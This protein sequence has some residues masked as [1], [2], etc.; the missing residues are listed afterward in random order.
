MEAETAGGWRGDI[1]FRTGF[2]SIFSAGV[3]RIEV[4]ICDQAEEIDRTARSP[5]SATPQS[6]SVRGGGGWNGRGTA[7]HLHFSKGILVYFFGGGG[8][9]RIEVA[10]CDLAGELDCTA[11]LT[12]STTPHS[13]SVHGGGGWNGWGMTWRHR[14][15]KGILVEF[16]GRGGVG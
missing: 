1:V 5:T 4:A 3:G 2:W 9:V 8:G 13:I 10:I 11:Q 15:S 6:T 14:F 16:F 12:T 7:W